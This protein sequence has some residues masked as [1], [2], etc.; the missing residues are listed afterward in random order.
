MTASVL[1][2]GLAEVGG[3]FQ[4]DGGGSRND[5]LAVAVVVDVNEVLARLGTLEQ[6]FLGPVSARVVG[7]NVAPDFGVTV[8]VKALFPV[9]VGHPEVHVGVVRVPSQDDPD[10]HGQILEQAL[11]EV[12]RLEFLSAGC[13]DGVH[14]VES[15]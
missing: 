8:T 14:L 15:G 12:A 2:M 10:V 1:A 5:L 7:R 6:E 3:H 13:D 11:V 4:L 9:R